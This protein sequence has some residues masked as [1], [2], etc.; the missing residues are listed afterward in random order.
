MIAIRSSLWLGRLLLHYPCSYNEETRPSH[1]RPLAL[2]AS[3]LLMICQRHSERAIQAA[4]PR[5]PP[6]IRP[7]R[8]L[9]SCL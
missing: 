5:G 2:A 8:S 7:S 1:P 6:Q 4:K 9:S 3:R